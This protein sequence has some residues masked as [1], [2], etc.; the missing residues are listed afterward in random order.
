M[1]VHEGALPGS[2]SVIN[3]DQNR[4]PVRAGP[5]APRPL[6]IP[7][8][9]DGFSKRM[10]Q[11][12]LSFSNQLGIEGPQQEEALVRRLKTLLVNVTGGIKRCR[13]WRG[14]FPRQISPHEPLPACAGCQIQ[15]QHHS[16]VFRHVTILQQA[17]MMVMKSGG[18][19]SNPQWMGLAILGRTGPP[20][21]NWGRKKPCRYL[22]PSA[23]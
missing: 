20:P 1:G 11:W 22:S 17:V 8:T 18:L 7:G 2:L 21:T 16:C 9:P 23:L 19:P 5:A 12:F 14:W 15:M 6:S 10:C 4:S 3:T 13:L